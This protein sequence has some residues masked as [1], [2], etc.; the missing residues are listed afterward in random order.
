MISTCLK[1]SHRVTHV[2]FSDFINYRRGLSSAHISSPGMG[3]LYDIMSRVVTCIIYPRPQS[4]HLCGD[5]NFKT[6]LSCMFINITKFHH[7][8][9]SS[10]TNH[11]FSFG[12]YWILNSERGGDQSRVYKTSQTHEIC[13]RTVGPM[14]DPS[15]P[16][17]VESMTG[18]DRTP[19]CW[20]RSHRSRTR[21]NCGAHGGRD[22]SWIQNKHK[23]SCQTMILIINGIE[24]KY[25]SF[26]W[27]VKYNRSI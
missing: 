5:P 6:S 12:A 10:F 23:M 8:L 3:Y 20:Q 26:A 4:I 27:R 17:T 7:I 2:C 13:I 14:E 9:C 18:Q 24:I 11:C 22:S 1:H 15:L 25:R 16:R 21:R 19:V